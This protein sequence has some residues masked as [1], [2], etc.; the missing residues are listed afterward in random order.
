MH[1]SM[2]T[3]LAR[4]GL[5]PDRVRPRLA[6]LGIEL[7]AAAWNPRRGLCPPSEQA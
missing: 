2:V 4:I 1:T 3:N 7:P 6:S 5:L